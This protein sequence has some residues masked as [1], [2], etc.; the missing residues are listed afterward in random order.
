MKTIKILT[1]FN[2]YPG[3]RN[4]S[5]SE[6]SG[7]LFYHKILNGQFAEAFRTNNKLVVDLDG[8]GGYASSFLDE[9]FGN[10]V[11]DFTLEIVNNILEIISLEEPH[12]KSMIEEETFKQ[13]E[14]RRLNNQA[15]KV[16][17]SHDSWFRNVGGKLVEDIWALPIVA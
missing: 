7:E 8:T 10:L 6:N 5:I 13:W 16:T 14:T 4:C 15:P 17:A 3:L 9:A 1:D 12:W 11:Y 2:E